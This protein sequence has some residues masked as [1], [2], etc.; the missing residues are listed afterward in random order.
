MTRFGLITN[1]QIACLINYIDALNNAS[2]IKQ[3]D[4]TLTQRGMYLSY[5]QIKE[6]L[7]MQLASRYMATFNFE[8]NKTCE[9]YVSQVA[10]AADTTQICS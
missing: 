6:V 10:D 5:N 1:D 8:A 9:D 4:G 7:P 2:S 3:A